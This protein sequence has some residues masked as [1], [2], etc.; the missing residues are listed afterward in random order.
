MKETKIKVNG[1]MCNGCENRI[2]NAL[3]TI[4][5]VEEVVANHTTGIVTV[6]SNSNVSEE[7]MKEKI[8]DIGFEVE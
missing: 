5:G 3:K 4:E 6:I 8:E 2:Q 1:M 7:N